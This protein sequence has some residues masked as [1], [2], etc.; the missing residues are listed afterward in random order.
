MCLDPNKLDLY[1]SRIMLCIM[2][3]CTIHEQNTSQVRIR[4]GSRLS[5]Y[6]SDVPSGPFNDTG[7]PKNFVSALKFPA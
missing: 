2:A 7:S 5:P 3:Y 6:S 1:Y 4:Q